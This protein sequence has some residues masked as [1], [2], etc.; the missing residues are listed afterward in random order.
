MLRNRLHRLAEHFKGFLILAHSVV[1]SVRKWES[2]LSPRPVKPQYIARLNVKGSINILES[3]SNKTILLHIVNQMGQS[4]QRLPE[5]VTKSVISDNWKIIKIY[6][7]LITMSPTMLNCF[8]LI[9]ALRRFWK[10]YLWLYLEQQL[11]DII[12]FFSIFLAISK[13]PD[14]C[15]FS[16]IFSSLPC[17][18]VCPSADNIPCVHN[19]LH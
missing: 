18:I 15:G 14:L 13:W 4:A 17:Q 10:S 12:I 5:S 1:N 8:V 7:I 6:F 2:L 11:L 3:G 9:I 16:G 19:V